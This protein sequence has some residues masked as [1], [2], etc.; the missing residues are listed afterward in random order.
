M[1][2]PVKNL[3]SG[4][5]LLSTLNSCYRKPP[6]IETCIMGNIGLICF[7]PRLPQDQQEYVIKYPIVNYICTSPGDYEIYENWIMDVLTD[8]KK[9]ERRAR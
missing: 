9:C 2:K 3:L 7:D 4:L 5:V 6:E 8:L 1:M